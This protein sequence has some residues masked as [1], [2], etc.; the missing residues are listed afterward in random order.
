LSIKYKNY[1][2]IIEFPKKG[3]VVFASEEKLRRY[4]LHIGSVKE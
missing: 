3:R 2:L 4:L 1:S